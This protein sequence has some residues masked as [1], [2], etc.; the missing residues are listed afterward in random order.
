MFL[1]VGASV[2][3]IVAVVSFLIPI[4]LFRR[5]IIFTPN[6]GQE[7]EDIRNKVANN[8]CFECVSKTKLLGKGLFKIGCRSSRKHSTHNTVRGS[9]WPSQKEMDRKERERKGKKIK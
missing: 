9:M 4:A 3:E 1:G 5:N 6:T 7:F 8:G 2:L